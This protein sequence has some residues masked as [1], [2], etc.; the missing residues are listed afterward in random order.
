MKRNPPEPLSEAQ[1]QELRALIGSLDWTF[2]RT[3]AEI[4]HEYIVRFTYPD[5][6][7]TLSEAIRR[8][9]VPGEFDGRR[10]RYLH[11][12]GWRYWQFRIILN[13]ARR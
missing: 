3:M 9:G 7:Q 5:A 1:A 6:F 11:L 8:H 4:P 12:D 2:A 10:Y 13:R